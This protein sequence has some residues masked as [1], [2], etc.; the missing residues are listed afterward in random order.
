MRLPPI[1]REM[2]I[3]RSPMPGEWLTGP[4][5]PPLP[6][7]PT[8]RRGGL[9]AAHASAMRTTPRPESQ[10]TSPTHQTSAAES[11]QAVRDEPEG[12]GTSDD[13]ASSPVGIRSRRGRRRVAS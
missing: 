2:A 10:R 7:G 8:A 11:A 1:L 6:S 4:S 3:I 13:E 5:P 12:R 9:T